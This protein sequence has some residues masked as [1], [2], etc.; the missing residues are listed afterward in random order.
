MFDAVT[1]MPKAINS[2]NEYG[3]E[4]NNLVHPSGNRDLVHWIVHWQIITP[5]RPR[6][7]HVSLELG[8]KAPAVVF[9]GADLDKAV[10]EIKRGSLA[11]TVR[12]A[13]ASAGATAESIYDEV[14]TRLRS[15]FEATKVG[16]ARAPVWN[17]AQSSTRPTKRGACN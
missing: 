6:R 5:M 1:S 10:A 2:V 15:A 9:D 13:P 17:W 11:R 3:T 7:W 8:G 12:C 16:D 4:V 14:K